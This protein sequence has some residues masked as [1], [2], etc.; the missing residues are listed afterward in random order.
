[1][2]RLT[3]LDVVRGFVMVVMA[4]DH[5]RDFLHESALSQD[6]TDLSTTTP[7]LFFTRWITH[8]CAPT[9]VFLAGMSAF[10]ALRNATDLRA[11]RS[12]LLK[13][14]LWLVVLELTVI[15][16]ALWYDV[17]FRTTLFQVIFAIGMGLVVVSQASRLSANVLGISGLVIILLHGL[18]PP[19]A[20][21]WSGA[22]QVLWSLFFKFGVFPLGGDR[23]LLVLYPVVPWLGILLLGYGCGQVYTNAEYR[24]GGM[25]NLTRQQVLAGLGVV[26]LLLFVAMRTFNSYGDLRLWKPES[27][28]LFSLFSFVNVSKYPPSAQYSTLMVGLALLLLAWSDRA[29]NALTR[30]LSV[31]GKVPLFYYVVHWYVIHTLVIVLLYATGHIPTTGPMDFGRP[32]EW[33]WSLPVIYAI[34]A[35]VVLSLYPLCRWFGQYKHQYSAAKPWLRYV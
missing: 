9:F 14:G 15:N 3:S 20:A 5:T 7:L 8:L 19:A 21:D 24:I 23:V 12:L 16:F 10:L 1:M 35:A 13:R 25:R 28:P 2:Q 31:Y 30:F 4:L 17:Q 11:A 6:P 18:I 29:N 34:W 32:V 26:L 22:G 27:S 33:G